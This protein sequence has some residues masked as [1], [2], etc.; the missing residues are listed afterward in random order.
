M[1]S[2]STDASSNR[3]I[4]L[5]L[6]ILAFLWTALRSWGYLIDDTFITLRFARNLI[7]GSGLVFNP[8]ERVEGYTSFALVLLS[9]PLLA[10]GIDPVLGLGILSG[11]A[12][13]WTLLLTA[14]LERE[15]VGA[16]AAR[17]ALSALL[18]S[19][20]APS[21]TGRCARWRRCSSRRSCWPP[22]RSRCARRARALARIGLRLR[23]ALADAARGAVPLRRLHGGARAG[24]ALA[25][26]ATGAH[27]R[28]HLANAA[29]R[30][31]GG[32][33]ALRLAVALLRRA[34]SQYVLRQGDGRRGQL[35]TGLRYLR[36]FSLAFPLFA[37]SLAFP[38]ALLSRPLR[39]RFA[40]PAF[41]LA[42]YATLAAYVL[43]VV[44]VGAD[45][46]PY[47]R[48]FV[49]VLPLCAVL[50]AGLLRCIPRPAHGPV[51]LALF[52]LQAA[53]GLATEQPYRAFVAHRTAQV[54][55]RVGAWLRERLAPGRL[56]RR[57][58]GGQPAVRVEAPTIDML[59]LTD[60]Q[61]AHRP[62]YIVS[63][64]WAGHRRGWGEY[65]LRRRPRVIL[66][67]NSAGLAEPHYLSDHELADD[68]LFRF[69]YTLRVAMLPPAPEAQPDAVLRRYLGFPFGYDPSGASSIPDLGLRLRFRDSPVDLTSLLEGPLRVVTFELDARDAELW[70]EG[71]RLRGDLRAFVDDGRGAL[72]GAGRSRPAIPRRAPRW[73][74]SARRRCTRSK[75]GTATRRSASSRTPRSSTAAPG[76]PGPAVRRQPGRDVRARSSPRSARRR[77]RCDSIRETA[78]TARTCSACSRSR[79]RARAQ[80]RAK[81]SRR[82]SRRQR[83]IV[84]AHMWHPFVPLL[85]LLIAPLAC[86]PSGE[87]LRARQILWI[88]LAGVAALLVWSAWAGG[89]D[90]ALLERMKLLV[91]TAAIVVVGCRSLRLAGM[92]DRRVYLGS[93]SL[94]AAVAWVVYPNFFAFHGIGRERVFIH[95]HDVAHY[96]L[97]AKYFPELGYRSLYTAMLRAEAEK[98]E[99][100]FRSLEARDLETNGLVDIRALLA[101]S[102]AVKQR[103]SAERWAAFQDDVGVLS[104]WHEGAVG[105]GPPG[106]R[107]QSA[108]ALA[109]ARRR[110]GQSGT[111][112]KP[113]G[114][115]RPDA[116]RSRSPA[117]DVRSHRLGVRRRVDAAGVDLL[118]HDLTARRSAGSGAAFF[119]TSGLRAWWAPSVA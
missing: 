102:D 15:L 78:S 44:A 46:M 37:A 60:A 84:F 4:L 41:A 57:Q 20:P 90:F 7:E 100:H 11:A 81:F 17:P 19:R 25:A 31:R 73:R 34:P 117:R 115:P 2:R 5:L 92:A 3:R 51:V 12:A 105:G 93:L 26:A 68:P 86:S 33:D 104:R 13:V 72:G 42:I 53:A 36:E 83:H 109:A 10:L 97:G 88:I 113:R 116:A 38:L 6:A 48:F 77:R 45:F 64:G 18:C 24:G 99:N 107:L 76:R 66:W 54:G 98:Y 95:L 63:E 69:F 14:R 106:P 28:R 87:V 112:G 1:S 49:P 108:P 110:A 82:I 21:R 103:F 74:A 16:E 23:P 101:R 70:Q 52:A 118:L 27:L 32:G 67:Y 89:V 50:A 61:I 65:V 119:A 9:A 96:Y 80:Q 30:A 40:E 39:A 58:H 79:T 22:C 55:E 62:I 8:G 111:A 29:R 59:G 35:A 43:Y 56:D 114:N 94:I 47:F 71:L 91:A 85:V 75:R